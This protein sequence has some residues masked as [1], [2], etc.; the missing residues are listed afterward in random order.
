[1][2]GS[3]WLD[4]GDGTFTSVA[5]QSGFS[6]LDLYLMGMIPTEQA[7]PMPLIDNAAIDKTKL[8]YLADTITLVPHAGNED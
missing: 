6:P 8:P 2:Y 3:G 5:K 4:N 1:M 7:S